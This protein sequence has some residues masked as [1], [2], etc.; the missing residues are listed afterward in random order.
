M[1]LMVITKRA[2]FLPLGSKAE[3]SQYFASPKMLE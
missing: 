2:F 3:L 1:K